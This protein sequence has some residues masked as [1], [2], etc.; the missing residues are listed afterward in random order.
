MISFLN[1]YNYIASK[2]ILDAFFNYS[3]E[4]YSGY[5]EDLHTKNA[6]KLIQSKINGNSD[7]YFLSGGTITNRI[8]LYQM[9]RPYEAVICVSSGHI[10]VHETGAVES[11]GHKIL[12]VK[13]KNGKID[14]NEVEEL[15]NDHTDRHKV[16]PK[17]IYISNS[18]EIGK[19][20]TLNELKKFIFI[21]RWCSFRCSTYS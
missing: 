19:I 9:L 10:N 12:T 7:I 8:G 17:V 2:D 14:L 1:D 13:G 5:A 16:L 20:Y 15:L 3:N 18:T 11:T 4:A 6:I 21:H